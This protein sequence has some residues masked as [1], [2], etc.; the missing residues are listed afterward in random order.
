LPTK[1]PVRD[2]GRRADVCL[3]L[4]KYKEADAASL[5]KVRQ[6][7]RIDLLLDELGSRRERQ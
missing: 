1:I 6:S 3:L 4:K 5:L 2:G 7:F